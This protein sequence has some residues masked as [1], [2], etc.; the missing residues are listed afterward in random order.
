MEG[1][2]DGGRGSG[3]VEVRRVRREVHDEGVRRSGPNAVRKPG[4]ADAE[5][6][7]GAGSA[8]GLHGVDGGGAPPAVKAHSWELTSTTAQPLQTRFEW[9][10]RGCLSETYTNGPSSVGSHAAQAYVPGRRA[11][12]GSWIP[13]DCEEALVKGVHDL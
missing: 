10:C 5:G 7:A 9:R 2:V 13:Q 8:G 6:H 11:L 3:D 1:H 12:Q 4:P